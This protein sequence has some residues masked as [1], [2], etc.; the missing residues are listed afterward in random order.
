MLRRECHWLFPE[1]MFAV[2]APPLRYYPLLPVDMSQIPGENLLAVL[3]Q[4]FAQ[5]PWLPPHRR[6]DLNA[7]AHPLA[8]RTNELS[9]PA[10]GLNLAGVS[11][12]LPAL[13]RMGAPSEPGCLATGLRVICL[14]H[15]G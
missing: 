1:E 5:G 6:R 13:G 4:L 11:T 9:G 14:T 12:G 3:H 7:H 8:P 15:A 2:P 10:P